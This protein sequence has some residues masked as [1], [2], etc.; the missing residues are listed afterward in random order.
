MFFCSLHTTVCDELCCNTLQQMFK[1]V[2]FNFGTRIK[3]ILP[4]INRRSNDAV[5]YF[6]FQSDSSSF[7]YPS[8]VSDRQA[9]AGLRKSCI[10]LAWGRNC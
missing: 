10:L 4:V 6:M 7:K 2:S 9:P 3:V 8:M 5:L 1:L